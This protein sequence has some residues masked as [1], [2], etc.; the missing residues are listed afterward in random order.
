VVRGAVAVYRAIHEFRT[1]VS[2]LVRLEPLTFVV[3]LTSYNH[4]FSYLCSSA[5]AST[6]R[7]CHLD[8][9]RRQMTRSRIASKQEL[10]LLPTETRASSHTC[11]TRM[12]SCKTNKSRHLNPMF[13][14]KV[15]ATPHRLQ[16]LQTELARTLTSHSLQQ[17]QQLRPRNPSSL[18]NLSFTRLFKPYTS[19]NLPSK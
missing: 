5:T 1:A 13:E 3:F 18:Y 2:Y 17:P 12:R 6:N 8:H 14:V 16:T 10:T 4:T 19:A 15:N 11:S 7:L 9:P